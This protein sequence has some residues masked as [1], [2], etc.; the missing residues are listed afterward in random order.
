MMQLDSIS[1]SYTPDFAVY[2]KGTTNSSSLHPSNRFLLQRS[3]STG[4]RRFRRLVDIQQKRIFPLIRKRESSECAIQ[5]SVECKERI[6][7]AV[8]TIDRIRLRTVWNQGLLKALA[9][10]AQTLGHNGGLVS[11][12]TQP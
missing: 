1:A 3:G 12:S 2:V 11:F 9:N 5:S 7:A 6:S 10:W 8:Q 4:G